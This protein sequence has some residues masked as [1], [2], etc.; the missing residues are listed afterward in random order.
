MSAL[1]FNEASCFLA[2]IADTNTAGVMSAQTQG[3]HWHVVALRVF[4]AQRHAKYLGQ[5]CALLVIVNQHKLYLL[6]LLLLQASRT[7][8]VIWWAG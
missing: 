6:L 8:L 1:T 4:A 3:R 5:R 7:Q 2:C